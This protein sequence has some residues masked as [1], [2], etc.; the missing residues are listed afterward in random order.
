MDSGYGIAFDGED[1]WSFGNSTAR[2]VIIFAVAN[3]S[4]SYADNLKN[5]FLILGKGWTF[6][7]INGRFGSAKK[8]FKIYFTKSDT[9]FCL[10]LHILL[11]IVIYLLK[12]KK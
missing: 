5:N 4:S 7:G 12:E 6:H 8:K 9:K 1:W 10:S 3:S 11:I 2:N